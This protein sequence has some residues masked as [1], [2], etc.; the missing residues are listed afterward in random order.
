MKPVAPAFTG[1]EADLGAELAACALRIATRKQRDAP[2]RFAV[3]HRDGPAVGDAVDRVH[4]VPRRN[5]IDDESHVAERVAAN[6][7]LTIEVV[8]RRG[9]RQGLYRAHRIVEHRAPQ[10][11]DLVAGTARCFRA[12]SR[13]RLAGNLTR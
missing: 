11:F 9:R 10:V 1:L 8:G 2:E 6:G 12:P 4:E 7:E 13:T 3:D 5:A